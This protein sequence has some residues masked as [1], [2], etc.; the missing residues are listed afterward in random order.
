MTNK[1]LNEVQCARCSRHIVFFSYKGKE[2]KI[3]G[4]HLGGKIDADNQIWNF[5]AVNNRIS[6]NTGCEYFKE[7]NDPVQL[8]YQ[9]QS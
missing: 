2:K 8:V 3:D 1:L 4:C 5:L 6:G 7:S 9:Q